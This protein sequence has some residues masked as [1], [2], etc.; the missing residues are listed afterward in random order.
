[1]KACVQKTALPI[2]G[3]QEPKV[4]RVRDDQV[5]R[6][7]RGVPSPGPRL[8][9]YHHAASDPSPLSLVFATAWSTSRTARRCSCSSQ[10]STRRALARRGRK[11]STDRTGQLLFVLRSLVQTLTLQTL[12]RHDY[13]VIHGNVRSRGR[14]APTRGM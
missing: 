5:G 9:P 11:G 13:G 3:R 2:F 12:R 10:R 8:I 1:M 4:P 6:C 7:C 14:A